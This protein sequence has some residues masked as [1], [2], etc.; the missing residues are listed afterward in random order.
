MIILFGYGPNMT[1]YHL[2]LVSAHIVK[3]FI[4]PS[5][6]IFYAMIFGEKFFNLDKKRFFFYEFLKS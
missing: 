6:P 5:D 2:P 1:C 4:F 3:I